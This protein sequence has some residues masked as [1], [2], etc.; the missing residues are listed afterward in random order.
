MSPS[1]LLAVGTLLGI[2]VRAQYFPQ[3]PI[4]I[5]TVNSNFSN[6]VSLSYKE[7]SMSLELIVS[8]LTRP[9]WPVRDHSWSQIDIWLCQASAGDIDGCPNQPD[10]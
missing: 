2:A 1:S 3:V 7:V 10:L 8:F 4:N 9:E 6:G 5:Q